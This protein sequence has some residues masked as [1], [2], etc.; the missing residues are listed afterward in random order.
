MSIIYDIKLKLREVT[1]Q[2]NPLGMPLKRLRDDIEERIPSNY[3]V[4]IINH[5][6][7][8]CFGYKFFY[9]FSILYWIRMH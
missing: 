2:V 3:L 4:N 5:T 9:H 1:N 7:L 8:T 6:H